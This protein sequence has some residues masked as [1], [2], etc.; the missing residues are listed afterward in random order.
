MKSLWACWTLAAVLA[1]GDATRPADNALGPKD[2]ADAAEET[3]GPPEP[4]ARDVVPYARLW[5]RATRPTR[6]FWPHEA[7][8]AVFTVREPRPGT[9]YKPVPGEENLIR[10]DLQPWLGRPIGLQS[11]TWTWE[12]NGPTEVS[13]TL[14]VGCGLPPTRSLD[15]A[16]PKAPLDL[17]ETT[18]GCIEIIFS[19]SDDTSITSLS[20]WTTEPGLP[21]PDEAG[22]EPQDLFAPHFGV[23]EGFYG[24]PW[25]WRERSRMVRAMAGFGLGAYLYAPK[26]D[27]LHRALWRE[28]YPEDEMDR[29]ET[30]NAEA[31]GLGVTV[32]FGL[33]P[34]VDYR[35]GD[36]DYQ[37]LVDKVRAFAARGFAAFALLADDIE[38]EAEVEV[39]GGL[40][41]R[42]AGLVNRLLA[43]LRSDVPDAR[44]WFVPTVY[45]D[46]RLERWPGAPAYLAALSALD[47]EVEVMWT[48]IRTSSATMTA[49][50]MGR[51][52][53][54]VGRSPLIWDNFWANDGGDL[55]MGRIL[56]APFSGRPEGLLGAVRGIAHNLSLQGALTRLALGTFAAWLQDPALGPAALLE[57][58][59][60][61][62]QSFAVGAGRDPRHDMRTLGLLMAAF[63]GSA[64]DPYPR[65]VALET[66]VEALRLALAKGEG[67]PLKQA[68]TLLSL[69]ARMWALPGD[70]H[71]SGLDADLVD[72]ACFPAGKLRAEAEVGLWTLALLGE[73]L[74]GGEGLVAEA[75]ADEALDASARNRFLFGSGSLAALLEEVRG[76][77]AED[78][79]FRSPLRTSEGTPACKVGSSSSW[80]GWT[81]ATEVFVEGLPGAVV[82]GEGRVVWTPPHAGTFEGVAIALG[83]GGWDFLFI[84]TTCRGP[85]YSF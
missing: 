48:G 12:G 27:P 31:R 52:R 83:E 39:D 43:D 41:E 30:F 55:F 62:E 36:D 75:R 54:L 1:C 40:G 32:F 3:Q 44:M 19:A 59:V 82:D 35:D 15:W 61:A 37:V 18:A 45:S 28:P 68:R 6:G 4:L 5:A 24:L 7:W 57:R 80:L 72:D 69:L 38:F 10:V 77:S 21:W 13:V 26:D 66:A 71:H 29:F 22:P 56:L 49:E 8:D 25:S 11:A 74:S 76:L 33:S 53:A 9:G 47:P 64:V 60:A 78:R 23:I 42:H 79:G 85:D 58:A 14:A 2:S 46:E 70:L 81:G 16:E 34:F 84:E 73:R 50:D 65:F 17:Q 20:V 63:E 51:F 67:L